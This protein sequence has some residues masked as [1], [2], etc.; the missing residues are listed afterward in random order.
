MADIRIENMV[1]STTIAPELDLAALSAALPESDYNPAEFPG[2]VLRLTEPKTAALLFRSGKVVCTGGKTTEDVQ[3]AI[4]KVI[5]MASSAGADVRDD[6]K[7]QVQNIVASASLGANLNLHAIALALGLEKVEYEPEQFPGLV[8][9]LEEPR[10][11]MLLFS[12]GKLVCTGARKQAQ[13]E[14]AVDQI[15]A[16]LERRGLL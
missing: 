2:L 6:P 1:A 7:I 13:V 12:S 8:Y 5:D 10:V 3:Q 9:R 11:V 14:E 4:Q 16:E 15:A